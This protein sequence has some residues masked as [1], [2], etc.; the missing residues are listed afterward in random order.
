MNLND[1][2]GLDSGCPIAKTYCLIN[3]QP[4]L[5]LLIK[6]SSKLIHSHHLGFNMLTLIAVISV[7]TVFQLGSNITNF[8]LDSTEKTS[9]S[10]GFPWAFFFSLVAAVGSMATAAGFFFLWW[11]SKLTKTQINQTQQEIDSTLRPWIGHTSIELFTKQI[12]FKK[13]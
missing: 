9:L 7:L 2:R 8:T 12:G 5:T 13:S 10:N 4:F 1:W 6:Y 3:Y 11:Q